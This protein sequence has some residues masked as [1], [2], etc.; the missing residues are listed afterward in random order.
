MYTTARPLRKCV[1]WRTPRRFTC[2][3]IAPAWPTQLTTSP[4]GRARE[5]LRAGYFARARQ[6]GGFLF[7]AAP[8]V[9]GQGE[10]AKELQLGEHQGSE[11]VD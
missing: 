11:H 5:V 8:Y 6:A 9:R 10:D 1:S 3:Y 4:A 2:L 7:A